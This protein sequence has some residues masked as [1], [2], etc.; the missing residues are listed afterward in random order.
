MRFV[1]TGASGHLGASLTSLLIARGHEVLAVVREGSELHRLDSLLDRVTLARAGLEDMP[2]AAG[3]IAAFR[4]DAAVH[5]AWMGVSAEHRDSEAQLTTNVLGTLDLFRIVREAG[6]SVFLG[7]GSQA[8][9]GPYPIALTEDLPVRPRTAYGVA[10]LSAGLLTAKL[11]ELAGMRHAWIRLVATY[12]PADDVRHLI[13]SFTLQ[14]IRGQVP[15]LSP[16]GQMCDYLYV[17]DAAEAIALVAENDEASGVFVLGSGQVHSVREI[18]EMTRDLIDPAAET[19]FGAVPY[20]SDQVMRL[21]ADVTRIH[22]ATGWQPR[23]SLE[24]GL[25]QTVEYFRAIELG[26]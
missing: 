11:A 19:G 2:A 7:L 9:F 6:C 4:P 15:Q 22:Q 12:G 5:L 26:R 24:E 16:G 13:P 18:C 17:D 20:R 21:Q 1:V 8:E 23:T 25:V 10:K 3:A 14:L